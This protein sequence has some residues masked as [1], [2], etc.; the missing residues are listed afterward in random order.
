MQLG[1]VALLLMG[2][3]SV[4]LGGWSMY[5]EAGPVLRGGRTPLERIQAL[6]GPQDPIG[7][8]ALTIR[9]TLMDCQQI[10]LSF[11]SVAMRAQPEQV[12]TRLLDRCETLAGQALKSIAADGQTEAVLA[13]IASRRGDLAALES[14]LARS[15]ALAPG[16]AWVASLRLG[17][18]E[19]HFD[20]L[21]AEAKDRHGRDVL[22]LLQSSSGRWQLARLYVNDEAAR[23]RI[24]AALEHV[25]ESEQGS[26]VYA[27]RQIID[28]RA[29]S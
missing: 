29:T 13:M 20:A 19:R 17:L 10:L 5:S 21:S 27:V 15:Q 7:A 2:V 14:H 26:F 1:R 28:A 25:T 9:H 3:A 24:V 23:Q 16:L 12:R 18:G 4:L 11:D 6:T 8:S 22:L